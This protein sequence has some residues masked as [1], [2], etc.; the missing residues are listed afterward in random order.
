LLVLS[1][2]FPLYLAKAD[3]GSIK[4]SFTVAL[5]ISDVSASNITTNSATISW[6]TNG[7]AT[8]QVFYDTVSH[9][10]IADYAHCTHKDTNLVSEHSVTLAGLPSETTYHY[11]VSAEAEIHR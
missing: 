2:F 5:S 11:R 7:N 6:K 1:L 8:S 3:S 4:A 10:S 9:D